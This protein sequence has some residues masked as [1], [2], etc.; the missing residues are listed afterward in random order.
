M[1]W[2]GARYGFAST[3]SYRLP[4]FSSSYAL[5]A[6]APSPSTIKLA[7]IATAIR[8][9]S[10]VEEGKHLFEKLRTVEVTAELP[11]KIAAFK[12]FIKRLKAKRGKR[13]FER[14]FGIREYVLYSDPLGIYINAPEDIAEKVSNVLKGIQ[15]FGTSDSLCTCLESGVSEPPV[16]RCIKPFKEQEE[17]LIFLLT[18]FT[19]EA[20]FENVNP[21]SGVRLKEEEHLRRVPYLF[22]L[23]ITKKES[24]YT[25]YETLP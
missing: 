21:Y 19:E 9:S 23:R 22:P 12:S 3:F 16:E 10:D 17:G 6:P 15:Y 25:I 20:S 11:P 13:G 18:D 8:T 7:I 1:T 4:N 14:T 5:S 2:I 24:N